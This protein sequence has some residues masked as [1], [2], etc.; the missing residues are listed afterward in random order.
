MIFA[1]T[2]DY[3]VWEVLELARLQMAEVLHVDPS[4]IEA[5]ADLGNEKLQP[6]FQLPLEAAKGLTPDEIRQV[7]AGIYQ[8]C[9]EELNVRLAGVMLTRDEVLRG[10]SSCEEA[11]A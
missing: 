11:E 8:E 10:E 7:M 1:L 2:K 4:V 5:S 9:K 6:N 3:V